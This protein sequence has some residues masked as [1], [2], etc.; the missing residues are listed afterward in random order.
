MG[1]SCGEGGKGKRQGSDETVAH[2]ISRSPDQ[3][4]DSQGDS[5]ERVT[6]LQLIELFFLRQIYNR[7]PNDDGSAMRLQEETYEVTSPNWGRL[8]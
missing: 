8:E 6:R 4:P 7:S 3:C 2:K 5:V 1:H